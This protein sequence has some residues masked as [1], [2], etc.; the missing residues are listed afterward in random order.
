MLHGTHNAQMMFF[1]HI[2]QQC[3]NVVFN[4]YPE[5]G[6]TGKAMGSSK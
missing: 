3:L 2:L 1:E 4:V 6:T 5:G